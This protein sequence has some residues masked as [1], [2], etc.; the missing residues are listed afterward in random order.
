MF[1]FPDISKPF[2]FSYLY[3]RHL[4]DYTFLNRNETFNFP[5]WLIPP[6]FGI[7]IFWDRVLL[8]HPGWSAVAP[9][10]LTPL[11][12]QFSC[13]SLQVAGITS[14]CHHTQLIFPFLVATAFTTLARLVLNSWPQVICPPQ[15]P[16]V[17][18]LQVW[19]NV[20][21][22]KILIFTAVWTFV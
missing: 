12:K 9:S 7:Y 3:S 5:S 20:P 13:L 18:G 10:W 21:G 15:P 14:T 8:C 6:K 19:V 2:P 22:L 1:Y 11:F 4:V 16:K 17:L